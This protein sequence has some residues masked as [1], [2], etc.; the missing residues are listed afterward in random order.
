MRPAVSENISVVP[1]KTS[2]AATSEKMEAKRP[3][4]EDECVGVVMAAVGGTVVEEKIAAVEVGFFLEEAMADGG[5]CEVEWKEWERADHL[6]HRRVFRVEA[7][8]VGLQA[9]VACEDVIAFVPGE[10][11]AADG[12]EHLQPEDENEGG[13]GDQHPA[14]SQA[15]FSGEGMAG[16]AYQ[17]SLSGCKEKR[18]SFDLGDDYSS[19]G[20]DWRSMVKMSV[21]RQ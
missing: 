6:D 15:A 1:R 7:E 10:G 4:A 2:T 18:L 11:L 17:R 16:E 12:V 21:V 20:Q 8:V 13:H 9:L 3:G 5:D 14:S 19:S